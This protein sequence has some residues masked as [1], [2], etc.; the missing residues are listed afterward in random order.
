MP[1]THLI[2]AEIMRE[3]S[4]SDQETFVISISSPDLVMAMCKY[5]QFKADSLQL[6]D[7]LFILFQIHCGGG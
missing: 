6:K 3:S 7:I 5:P 2:D 1:F 4:T